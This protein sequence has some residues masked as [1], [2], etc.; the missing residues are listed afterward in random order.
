MKKP[1]YVYKEKCIWQILKWHKRKC[2]SSD[3]AHCVWQFSNACISHY[4]VWYF[5]ILLSTCFNRHYSHW[6]V[7]TLL[8]LSIKSL[9]VLY[10]TLKCTCYFM[11]FSFFF[12]AFLYRIATTISIESNDRTRRKWIWMT[13]SKSKEK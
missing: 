3:E 6:S 11:C 12:F 9:C 7:T 13:I 4:I 10:Y 8:F 5:V 1:T 2:L